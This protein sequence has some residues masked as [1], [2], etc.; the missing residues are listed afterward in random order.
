ML[1]LHRRLGVWLPPGGEMLADET[2]LEAALRELR[3]ETGLVGKPPKTSPLDGVPLGYLGY[4]EH[5][6]GSKGLHLNFVFVFDVDHEHIT[7]NEEF[8]EWRWTATMEGLQAP[9]NVGQFLDLALAV[10]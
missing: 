1:I 4:E 3:E 10:H 2:P 9:R 8:S 5:L 7:P 6:A